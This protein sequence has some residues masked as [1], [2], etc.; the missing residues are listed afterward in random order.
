[1]TP[2]WSGD[3][4]QLI[5]VRTP[6]ALIGKWGYDC[7]GESSILHFCF[8]IYG[9]F[10]RWPHLL[11]AYCM[12]VWNVQRAHLSWGKYWLNGTLKCLALHIWLCGLL[13]SIQFC[14]FIDNFMVL[15]LWAG[16]YCYPERKSSISNIIP[17]YQYPP[18]F[19]AYTVGFYC[20][21]A[22]WGW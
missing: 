9:K 5:A 17:V 21:I 22:Q 4:M 16:S 14:A 10:D 18:C 8:A 13:T 20:T 2:G 11:Y 7:A 6:H 15:Y 19:I 12:Q 1:M 3:L